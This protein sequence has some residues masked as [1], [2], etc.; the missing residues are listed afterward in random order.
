MKTDNAQGNFK[1]EA[2]TALL[3][4]GQTVTELATRIGKARNSVSIAIN[5]PSM[6]PGVKS[7]IR[8]HLKLKV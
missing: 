7:L 3:Q 6:L 5:H 1:V 4:T 2:K 8:S